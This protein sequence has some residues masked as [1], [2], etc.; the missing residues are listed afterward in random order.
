M[1]VLLRNHGVNLSGVKSDL[2]TIIGQFLVFEGV[3]YLRSLSSPSGVDS[4]HPSG[5]PS[6]VRAN[7]PLG[8]VFR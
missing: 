1:K 8:F 5:I 2:Y 4:K 7:L 6:T 3:I